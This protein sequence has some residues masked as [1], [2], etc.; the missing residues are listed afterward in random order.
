M[1]DFVIETGNVDLLR[2][3]FIQNIN[4]P[5]IDGFSPL[6]TAVTLSNYEMVKVLLR[7]YKADYNYKHPN[8]LTPLLAAT[9][10][11]NS[12]ITLLLL[13][14]PQIQMNVSLDNGMSPLHY[15]VL[16]S[17]I[18]VIKR[19]TQL[20]VYADS[21]ES[22]RN[23]DRCNAFLFAAKLGC[24]KE[25]EV[26]AV[27][28]KDCCSA[29]GSNVLHWAASSNSNSLKCT[30]LLYNKFKVSPNKQNCR[31]QYPIHV[32]IEARN[33]D[34]AIYLYDISPQLQ[35]IKDD[36]NKTAKDLAIT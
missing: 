6:L 3:I 28:N 15:A 31:K 16:N 35:S 36:K 18:N 21:E 7:D 1:I 19:M 4:S 5:G 32:A 33:D 30:E 13:D 27:K 14:Q 22:I 20:G 10:S 34:S 2:N 9:Q 23:Q 29:D 25:L 24:V 17:D 8:G 26:M 11:G 12:E